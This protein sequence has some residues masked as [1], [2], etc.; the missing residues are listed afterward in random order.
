M[1]I[2]KDIGMLSK[3]QKKLFYMSN[4]RPVL[5][6]RAL[7]SDETENYRMPVEPERN[8]EV[9]IKFRT[10][11][12]N[13]D[14][15][16]LVTNTNMYVMKRAFSDV[17]FDYYEVKFQVGTEK[18]DYY[19][20][21]T[22]GKTVVY[23]NKMGV[24][25][26]LNPSYNFT[27]VPGFKTPDWAKGAVMYQIYTDRFCNGDKKNDVVDREYAYIGEGV[28]QVKDWYAYPKAMDVRSFYGGDLQGVLDK[29]D[30]LQD[31]G[32]DVIYFNPLFVSPSNHK[33]DIQ[34]YDYIDPH[35]G[36]I[37]ED[38]GEVLAPGDTNNMH[39][40]KYISR[41]TSKKNLEASN[42]F[43][44]H[45]V[46]EIHNR[47]MKVIL[48][49]VF[50]H[51]GSFNKWLDREGI[52]HNSSEQYE[53]GAYWDK[54][55]PYH[56]FFGFDGGEWPQN[57]KYE[58]WWGHDTLPK[59]NYEGSSKLEEYI[60]NIAAKWVSPP[61]NCDGWRLD[62]AADLGHSVNYNH[63]FWSKFRKTVK[64][65]NPNAVI[66]AEHYGDAHDWLGGD[67]WDTVMNYDAFMEP[68][69]W[70][71]TGLEKHSDEYKDNMLGNPRYFFDGMRHNMS[72][73]GAQAVAISMNELSNHDHS[74]FLTRTN[75]QVGRVATRGSEAAN[76]GIHKGI[77]REAVVVQMTWPGAP[78]IYYG[79]EAGLC[80]WTDPD[81]RRTYPWGREDKDLIAFHKDMIRIHKENPALMK[82]SLKELTVDHNLISYGRFHGDN[83]IIV[84]VN[85]SED[86]RR[87]VVPVWELGCGENC[88]VEQL[89]V[90]TENDYSTMSLYYELTNGMLD[91][92]LRGT[93]AVILRKVNAD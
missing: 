78:T 11:R 52:Y 35:F 85:N 60:L 59:L 51:C 80:G 54:E 44:V 27:I 89:M 67:Q 92:G 14:K 58:G 50:N 47:G 90:T 34:D 65:A 12:Y 74:R 66:L 83:I 5:N 71:L 31:L 7:F 84:I 20:E 22:A 79:D 13:V 69:T 3:E 49:G 39:A 19:F 72:R 61:Y 76:Q 25:K 38:E 15:V 45:V 57:G 91:I 87:V 18:I 29:L 93:S 86:E 40:T 48:D 36:V 56:G 21:V 9:T 77:F 1:I 53:A 64:K 82:G 24:C 42:E 8:E 2:S 41:V 70:F 62:V 4:V 46:E 43:F 68:L 6:R 63:D 28:E 26:D 32:V 37:V 81:C 88:V 75:H 10:Y 30:Y 23:Y 33:Y 16:V 73:M 55:S 17:V